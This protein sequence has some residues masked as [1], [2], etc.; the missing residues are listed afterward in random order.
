M[1]CMI[2]VRKKIIP[3]EEIILK[4]KIEWGRGL[5]WEKGVWGGEGSERIKRDREKWEKNRAEAFDRKP[6]FSIEWKVSEV[7]RFKFWQMELSRTYR[8]VSTV[9][10]PWLIKKLSSSY[11]GDRNFLN[12][13]RSCRE[14]IETNSQKLRWI[15]I[16]IIA[17]ERKIKRLDRYPSY[18]EVS[19]S[20][21]EA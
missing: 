18:R 19:R 1:K 5:E 11:R 14:A 6:W 9:K 7:L 15:E 13:S 4:P 3:N 8:E 17:R 20:C 21:R 2:N 16:L 12:R 10:W